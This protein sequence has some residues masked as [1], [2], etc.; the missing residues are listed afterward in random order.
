MSTTSIDGI[1]LSDL[2]VNSLILIKDQYNADENG[3]Y[4]K[5]FY[6]VFIHVFIGF[7]SF[8]YIW[9]GIAFLFYQFSQLILN[10]R[11][12]IFQGK[13][14]EGNS[15]NHTLVKMGEFFLGFLIGFFVYKF[16]PKIKF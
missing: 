6:Y 9:I 14:E 15:L 13:I 11:F 5:P 8:Y 3:I 1:S 2:S 4:K 16:H 12:F 10:K 7:L